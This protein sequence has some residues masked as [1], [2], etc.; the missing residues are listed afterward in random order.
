MANLTARLYKHSKTILTTK[1]LALIWEET[2]KN[3]LKTKIAYYVKKNV[4]VK[5][6]RGIFSKDKNYDERELAS[7][8]YI[9]SYISFETVLRDAGVIFQHYGSIFVA[10]Q[11]SKHLKIDNKNFIFRK[12]KNE[13][14]FNTS[15]IIFENNYSI[16]TTE[17]AFL[18]TIYLF[19][20]YYFDN[21]EG[22]NW[23]K[24]FEIAKIYK[25]TRMIK[26]LNKHYKKHV[27]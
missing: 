17:R 9:P 22:I 15:G 20:K 2:N 21:L 10:C 14:L 18:D 6:R 4:L 12:L 23:E 3:N 8:L 16:A 25:N 24:C 7:S 1:D 13:I 26:E 5:I 11:W 19:P 27:K